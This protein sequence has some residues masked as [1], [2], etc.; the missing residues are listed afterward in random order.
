MSK[1]IERT[2][3]DERSA[4]NRTS[5]RSDQWLVVEYAFTKS[6][7]NMILGYGPGR[8]N[9]IYERY[10]TR[11]P[12]LVYGVGRRITLHAFY[13]QLAVELGLLGLLPF[14][15]GLLLALTRVVAWTRRSRILFPVM[16]MAGYIVIIFTVSGSD[17]VSASL[18]GVGLF[19]ARRRS[20]ATTS[21]KFPGAGIKTQPSG[22][23]GAT[24]GL[25]TGRNGRD[26]NPDESFDARSP[27]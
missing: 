23:T 2:F 19:Y 18:L 8:G 7:L 17:T 27:G 12:G 14:V 21:A 3:S 26:L 25:V 10:S 11:V 15:S 13:M 6:A 24:T 16:C 1:G 20:K 22:V 9:D 5:G 4:A